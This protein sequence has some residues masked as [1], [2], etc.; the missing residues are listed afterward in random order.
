MPPCQKIK[1]PEIALRLLGALRAFPPAPGGCF[2]GT[3]DD[4][5]SLR[6]YRRFPRC[7]LQ[8]YLNDARKILHVTVA[9]TTSPNG[10]GSVSLTP[11]NLISTTAPSVR[12][13]RITSGSCG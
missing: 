2:P 6:A 4:Q 7:P 8:A 5:S 13:S 3:G 12:F 1:E 11:R 9:L 10:P